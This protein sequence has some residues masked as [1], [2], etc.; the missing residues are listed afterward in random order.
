MSSAECA[1]PTVCFRPNAEVN[2]GREHRRNASRSVLV[3]VQVNV[4]E[5]DVER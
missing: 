4:A 3:V 1:A 5:I 2:L